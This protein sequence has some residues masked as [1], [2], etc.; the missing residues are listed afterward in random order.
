MLLLPFGIVG[1]RIDPVD[2]THTGRM[3]PSDL[4]SCPMS[5]APVDQS[6][7]DFFR[8]PTV[9]LYLEAQLAILDSEQYDPAARRV[10][11]CESRI[12]THSLVDSS[13]LDQLPNVYRLCPRWH[14]LRAR[15]CENHRDRSGVRMAVQHMQLCLRAISETGDGTSEFPYQITFLT[16]ADDIV[17]A[18]GE[19]VRCQ[20]LVGSPDGYR[21]VL[22]AH[23]GD[24]FWFDVEV[25]LE[26]SSQEATLAQLEQPT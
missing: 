4:K 12:T 8:S 26:K 16:D 2:V 21:D 13:E 15:V 17:R 9:D 14:Y 3:A 25:L 6:I 20:Q 1:A 18:F 24:E 22:T 19:S 23:S 11:A 7:H 5:M 10:L